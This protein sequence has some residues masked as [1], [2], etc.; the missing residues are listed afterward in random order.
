MLS[1]KYTNM[2]CFVM[3]S[4]V[5]NDQ[6]LKIATTTNQ[7]QLLI[8]NVLIIYL[9]IYLQLFIFSLY[10]LFESFCNLSK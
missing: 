3:R 2:R 7:P 1:T 8:F 10:T 9:F 6:Q 4:I 5:M